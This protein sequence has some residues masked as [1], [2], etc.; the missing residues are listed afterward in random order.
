MASA[1]T[2]VAHLPPVGSLFAA[3]LGANPMQ[4]ALG[5]EVL[6]SLPPDRAAHLTDTTFFPG[7]ISGPFKH[8]LVIAFAAGASLCLMA[9]RAS[10]RR[11]GRDVNTEAER[12][13]RNY[14]HACCGGRGTGGEW[15]KELITGREEADHAHHR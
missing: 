10:W 12:L 13:T 9:A 6:R 5:P 4:T 15:P 2:R 14:S 1:T 7:L 11:R 3:F 8:G